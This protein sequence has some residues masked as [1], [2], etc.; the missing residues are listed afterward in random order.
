[1]RKK[2]VLLLAVLILTGCGSRDNNPERPG[3]VMIESME[4]SEGTENS[5]QAENAWRAEHMA[6]N[7]RYDSI[8]VSGDKVY[9]CC[10]ENGHTIIE[11][12]DRESFAVEKSVP[13]P[14]GA[15][16]QTI[17]ADTQGN[18]YLCGSQDGN[19]GFWKLD[20]DGSLQELK[21]FVLE[22]TE[23]AVFI[24]PWG[25]LV[26][27]RGYTYVWYRM[28]VPETEVMED[29]EEVE[30]DVYV[31]V[32]RIYIMDSQFNP[33]FYE[34]VMD[35]RGMRLL[36][37]QAGGN[38]DPL[39][40]VQDQEDIYTQTINVEQRTLG[41]QVRQDDS[42]ETS[43][44]ASLWEIEYVTAI[45]DGFWFC[46]DGAL[47]EYRYDSQEPEK[48]LNLST[49]GIYA[50]DILYLGK[51]GDS[52]EIIDNHGE[53]QHSEFTSL[54]RGQSDKTVLTLG[55][56]H[57][58]YELEGII[59]E[60]NRYDK[61]LQIQVVDYYREDAAAYELGLDQLKLDIVTGHAPDLL[62]VSGVDY[63]IFADKGVLADLYGFMEN[64]PELSKDMLM[65]SVI[66]AY[67]TDGH[68][69]NIAP[70]FQLYTMWGPK[71]VTG[72]HTGVTLEELMQIL[73]NNG[74]D[75]NAIFGF[76]VDEPAMRTLCTFGMDEFVDWDNKT[77]EFDGAYFKS[78]LTFVKEYK[79]RWPESF[80]DLRE[81]KMITAGIISS[82][83]SYQLQ[84][85]IYGEEIGFIGYPTASGSG[86]AVGFRGDQLA[87][88]A[89]SEKQQ[90]A[91]EF[92]K[93]FVLKGYDGQGFP[94]LKE[95]FDR[96]MDRALED[97]YGVDELGTSYRMNKGSYYM[98]GDYISVYAATQ[99]DVDAV[100]AL[101]ESAQNRYRYHIA[102]QNI[103]D[104]EAASYFSGQ[105][106]VDDVAAIIQNRASLYLQE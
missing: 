47:Y 55:V 77:C 41:E 9:G 37:F 56:V 21:D 101:V 25:I 97:E 51:S 3:S 67:E 72:A 32:D 10:Q 87:I 42:A 103:I 48:L 7:N 44:M 71:T 27:D 36:S 23:N 85:E 78:V 46:Q 93:Y 95:E 40:V 33:L 94:V 59:T 45:G 5:G 29:V 35:A 84:K 100:R 79:G 105:K 24:T 76:A 68:L 82:V 99:E 38:E 4:Q 11:Y 30:E 53:A 14:E 81:G 70:G 92:I 58:E 19:D 26:D 62:M 20:G 50:S 66:Q 102:L 31:D 69:Y 15:S 16:V 74:K 60:F 75:I 73:Q 12:L 65:P 8:T 80:D 64:D 13:L 52:I 104:E 91:W 1:M 61:D 86:T 98:G 106:S 63:D 2:I 39:L 96:T 88:N 18:V 43:D 89:R 49:F 90:E 57:L 22:D 83:A 6:L 17:A 34:Q 28:A 54:E